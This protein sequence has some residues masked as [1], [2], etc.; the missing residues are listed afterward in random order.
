M[1]YT[2]AVYWNTVY[3][4]SPSSE[5]FP[6]QEFF[7]TQA[8][9][10]DTITS[11]KTQW[12]TVDQI[13]NAQLSSF[14]EEL[15]RHLRPEPNSPYAV[16]PYV[17]LCG[18]LSQLVCVRR[19]WGTTVSFPKVTITASAI[20]LLK[21]DWRTQMNTSASL[22]MFNSVYLYSAKLQQLSSQGT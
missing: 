1:A 15:Y 14:W 10:T 13:Y 4:F 6:E 5:Y 2:T 9:I 16:A 12:L 3:L 22:V 20:T 19:S 17:V 7:C 11:T 21:W 18:T 8:L